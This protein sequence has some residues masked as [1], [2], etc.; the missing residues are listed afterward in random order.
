ML[1]AADLRAQIERDAMPE[2]PGD[3]AGAALVAGV[4][5]HVY[6]LAPRE[7]LSLTKAITID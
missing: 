5:A 1:G 4:E 3:Q 2:D 7:R 6:T